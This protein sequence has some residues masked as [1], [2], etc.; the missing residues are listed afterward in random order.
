MIKNYLFAAVFIAYT[1]LIIFG[2][3]QV[4]SGK[5][6]KKERKVIV[7]TIEEHNDA[8]EKIT[9]VVKEVEK[10]QIVYRDKIIRIPAVNPG[11]GCPVVELVRVRNEAIQALDPLLFESPN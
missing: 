7:A 5:E 8:V 10:V 4:V 1:G 2:T 6:A 11:D 9:D 3:W